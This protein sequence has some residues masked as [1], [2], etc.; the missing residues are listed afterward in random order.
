MENGEGVPPPNRLRSLGSVVSSPSGVWGGA[1]AENPI[2]P[3]AHILNQ[4]VL[5]TMKIKSNPISA[6]NV[7]KSPKFSRRQRNWGQVTR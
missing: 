6:L 1:P 7:R 4:E 3:Q 2:L 5:K